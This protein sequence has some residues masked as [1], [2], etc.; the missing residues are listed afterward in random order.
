MGETEEIWKPVSGYAG[1]Y[2]IS[3]LGR[4]KAL[5]KVVL[6]SNGRRKTMVER[7]MRPSI[8][9]WGYAVTTIV[10]TIGR[11]NV[12]IHRLV[13]EAFLPN[14]K[15]KTDVNHIDSDRTNNILSN[16]EWCTRKENMVHAAINNRI[17]TKLTIS[18]VLQIRGE[19]NPLTMT[20]K[21]LGKKYGV[22]ATMIGNIIHR[23]QWQNV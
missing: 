15:N 3:S 19:W 10:G 13:A 23:K 4:L 2:E 21:E 14:P 20:R 17:K 6:K 8:N 18:D 12:K 1:L 16:L 7:I 22:G 5:H 11:K 9:S